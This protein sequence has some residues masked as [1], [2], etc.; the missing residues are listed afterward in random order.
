MKVEFSVNKDLGLQATIVPLDIKGWGDTRIEALQA[1][2]DWLEEY[3]GI[4]MEKGDYMGLDPRTLAKEIWL[5]LWPHCSYLTESTFNG[6]WKM[7][8]GED[9][10]DPPFSESPMLI[11]GVMACMNSFNQ[12]YEAHLRDDLAEM[13]IRLAI[14]WFGMESVVSVAIPLLWK[15]L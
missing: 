6:V 4:V 12:E 14:W 3:A 15:E 8:L 13:A 10:F 7:L 11:L 2:R 9:N 1:A 5:S